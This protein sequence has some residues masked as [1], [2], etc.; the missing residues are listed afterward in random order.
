MTST[1]S[2][3]PTPSSVARPASYGQSCT[4]CAKSKCK[5]LRR[6]GRVECERCFRLHKQCHAADSIRKRHANRD[7]TSRISLLE[8]RLNEVTSLLQSVTSSGD[9]ARTRDSTAR[10]SR[11][12]AVESVSALEDNYIPGGVAMSI[13]NL[14]PVSMASAVGKDLDLPF[15]EAEKCVDV[16]RT[17]MLRFFAFVHLPPDYTATKIR[18]HRPFLYLCIVAVVTKSTTKKMSL[19][20]EIRR[21]VAHRMILDDASEPDVDLLLG[22]LTYLTW[23]NEHLLINYPKMLSRLTHMA[24]MIVFDLR[25]NKPFHLNPNLLPKVGGFTDRT[26]QLT[27]RMDARPTLE[28]R[29]AVLG[30]FVMA[31]T[32]A[33]HLTNVDAMQWNE[34]MEQCVQVLSEKKES[35]LD[36]LL[37]AQVRFHRLSQRLQPAAWCYEDI[38]NPDSKVPVAFYFKALEL[39]VQRTMEGLSPQAQKDGVVLACKYHAELSVCE[40]A[41]SQ[42]TSTSS[43]IGFEPIDALYACLNT[44]K[45]A[46]DQFFQIPISEY[47]A[48]SFPIF[49]QF[50]RSIAVLY[51]LTILDHPSWDIAL[52]RSTVDL[53]LVLDRL[54][55]NL[56]QARHVCFDGTDNNVA[57]RTIK[58]FTAVRLW[59]GSKLSAPA[60]LGL[61]MEPGDEVGVFADTST[62]DGLDDVW[63]REILASWSD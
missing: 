19:F 41:L 26:H 48:V 16:F 2:F 57:T 54:L 46:F 6:P 56:E 15:E 34:Y 7:A 42:L 58:G 59:C 18:Q 14:S 25:L 40:M 11:P 44:V 38:G 5:C 63:L 4:N 43:N 28:E 62:I 9:G 36:D 61:D 47:F 8:E 23:G 53:I 27:G 13:A 37:L 32:V 1:A 10:P 50:T 21:I 12:Q 55:N 22:L 52:V 3:P 51:K 60:P 45:L 33:T 35:P 49:T 24:M 31:S 29:R 17:Q 20:K 30:C 39:N